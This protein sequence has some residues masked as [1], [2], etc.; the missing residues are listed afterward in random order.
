[1]LIK[2]IAGPN[3]IETGIIEKSTR[4]YVFNKLVLLS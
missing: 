2:E 3:N 4:K 1:M